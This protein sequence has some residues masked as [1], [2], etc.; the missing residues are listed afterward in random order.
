M[1]CKHCLRY[2]ARLIHLASSLF[3]LTLVVLDF[4]FD[5]RTYGVV[6]DSALFKRLQ[7]GAGLT[8]IFSGFALTGLMRSDK[9]MATQNVWL[10]LVSRKFV[11]SLIL[12]PFADK[13]LIILTGQMEE[14]WYRVV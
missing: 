8:M 14:G 6:Q 2:A 10:S 13:L 12:T 4:L 1:D 3:T 7:A 9:A 5:F 11:A